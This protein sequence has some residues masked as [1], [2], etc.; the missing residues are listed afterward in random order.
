M[1]THS[2]TTATANRAFDYTLVGTQQPELAGLA[3]TVTQ[4]AQ[5]GNITLHQYRTSSISSCHC[6]IIVV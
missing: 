4:G 3:A 1:I 2:F 5:S 6:R